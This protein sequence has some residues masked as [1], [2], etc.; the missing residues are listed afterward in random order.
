MS[1]NLFTLQYLAVLIMSRFKLADLQIRAI[2]RQPSAQRARSALDHL[3]TNVNNYYNQAMERIASQK[4]TN[5]MVY[6]LLTWLTFTRSPIHVHELELA[7]SIRPGQSLDQNLDDQRVDVLRYVSLSEGLIS[8]NKSSLSWPFDKSTDEDGERPENK[9]G[10]MTREEISI[11]KGAQV[12]LAHE[13]IREFLRDTSQPGIP[14]KGDQFLLH[15]CLTIMNSPIFVEI[16]PDFWQ[17]LRYRE[18]FPS[19]ASRGL[20]LYFG[21]SD[22]KMSA[23]KVPVFLF[24]VLSS[25]GQHVS[26]ADLTVDMADALHRIHWCHTATSEWRRSLAGPLYWCAYEGWAEACKLLLPLEEDP[27]KYF[28]LHLDRGMT[29]DTEE[30]CLFAAVASGDVAT[31]QAFLDDDRIN[32]NCGKMSYWQGHVSPLMHACEQGDRDIV[33]LVLARNEVAVNRRGSGRHGAGL[34]AIL[35]AK[36]GI[37]A[38]LLERDD[39]D[40]NILQRG[41]RPIH[42]L[43]SMGGPPSELELLLQNTKTEVNSRTEEAMPGGRYVR[44]KYLACFCHKRTALMVAAFAGHP[45]QTSVLLKHPRIGL[46]LRDSQGMTAL[47]LASVGWRP[48]TMYHA[49]DSVE[50]HDET[51]RVLLKSSDSTIN[52][53]DVR[54]RT[55]LILASMGGVDPKW[56]GSDAYS[57]RMR[58]LSWKDWN[59]DM[60][61]KSSLGKDHHLKIVEAL[62]RDDNV[63]VNIPDEM[64]HT[65]LDYAIWTRDFIIQERGFEMQRLKSIFEDRRPGVP[66]SDGLYRMPDVDVQDR[67]TKAQSRM[68][69]VSKI[70]DVLVAS[71][72]RSCEP[73]GPLASSQDRK[74]ESYFLVV[75]EVSEQRKMIESSISA[76]ESVA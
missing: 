25:W 73:I 75:A 7:L 48:D 36:P 27:N 46:Q 31:V 18:D 51:V 28:G 76:L 56:N 64:G 2:L 44:H 24:W 21:T 26:G 9:M 41:R 68:D 20:S 71:G 67:M 40:V 8:I 63:D 66:D 1:R 50:Q 33:R 30:T 6:N 29:H 19:R 49:G 39:L 16:L 70:H 60:V 54:G 59:E 38:L 69:A 32:P 14:A 42:H 37:I 61:C 13:S 34:P 52:E 57:R 15:C 65:A 11:N 3:T 22:D 4:E 45:A 35:L 62:L 72:G 47:M 58:L 12:M 43:A 55:A 74:L 10:G 23:V 17:E 53:R 5:G